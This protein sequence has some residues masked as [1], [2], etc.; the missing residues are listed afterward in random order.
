MK[1]RA[2]PRFWS[3]Y[4]GLPPAVQDQARRSDRESIYS[5]RVTRDYRTLGL[6]EGE[7]ITWFWIGSHAEY[8]RLIRSL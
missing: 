2:T 3:A 1:S 5:A 7:G 8:D 4:R 6:L